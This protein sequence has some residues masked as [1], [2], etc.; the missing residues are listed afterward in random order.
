MSTYKDLKAG[1]NGFRKILHKS[2][3][4]KSGITKTLP[5]LKSWYVNEQTMLKLLQRFFIFIFK[6]K[7]FQYQIHTI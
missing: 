5:P 3:Q 4:L 7:H 2:K 6:K 1:K